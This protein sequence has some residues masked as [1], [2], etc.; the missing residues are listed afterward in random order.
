MRKGLLFVLLLLFTLPCLA[1]DSPW[2]G[3]WKLNEAKSKLTGTT[4]TFTKEGDM[5]VVDEGTVKFKFACDGKEYPTLADRTITCTQSGSVYT[6]V[7][8]V[9]GTVL[10][11]TTH[12]ISSD[13]DTI[14]ETSTG[15]R[16]DGTA[17]K[18]SSVSKRV[19]AGQGLVGTWKDVKVKSSVPD[20]MVL[21]VNGDTLRFEDPAYK[22]VSETKLD[23]T[24][25]PITGGSAPPGLTYASTAEGSSKVTGTVMLDGKVLGKQEMTLSANGKTITDVHWRPGKEAEKTTYIYEKQ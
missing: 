24:P 18:N 23:G 16:P 12:T 21:Q 8:K 2:N 1:A 13:G 25:G 10:S 9:G 3:S 5:Y 19:G 6:T 4:V 11:T 14:T 22:E 17:F 20:V 15:T 7:A